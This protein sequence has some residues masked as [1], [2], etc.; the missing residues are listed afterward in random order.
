MAVSADGKIS[1]ASRH[2][3]GWTSSRDH[4]RLLD[5]RRGPQAIIAGRTTVLT[6]RMTMTAPGEA[7]PPLRCVVS[8]SQALPENHPVF[9]RSGGPIHCLFTEKIPPDAPLQANLHQMSLADFIRTLHR[10]H[11]VNHLHCEGGGGLIRSLAELDWLDE[12]HLTLAG[13][14]IIGGTSAP[15]LT[16]SPADFLPQ[17]RKFKL[18]LFET[19]PELGECY[20]SWRCLH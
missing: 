7:T 16:G 20:T 1:S 10:D 17:S 6:D 2:P 9:H 11:A 5:L 14:T 4:Q 15:T 3:C 8:R 18:M 12:L 13:H 19:A